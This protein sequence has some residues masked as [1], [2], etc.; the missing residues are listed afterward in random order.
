MLTVTAP[1]LFSQNQRSGI[2]RE[3]TGEVELKPAGAS[4]FVPARSGDEVA[5]NTVISTGFKGTAIIEVGSSNITVR[6]LT[7]LSLAEI[8]ISSGTENVDMNLQSGRIKV[9]VKPPAGTKTN[10]TVQSPSA[11]ASVRGTVFDFDTRN[12][13]V[14][15]GKVSFRGSRG[16]TVPVIAG[17]ESYVGKES[18]VEHPLTIVFDNLQPS[19]PA[20]AGTVAGGS[21][22]ST[23]KGFIVELV[24]P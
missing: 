4:A 5:L 7:R 10:F 6:P 14:T 13:K 22:P 18:K 24:Y 23:N 9:D 8:Q 3:L 1:G 17:H 19:P 20:G 16:M 21:D 12:L 11:T 15:E 2:I